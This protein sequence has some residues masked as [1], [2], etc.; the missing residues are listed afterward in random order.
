MEQLREEDAAYFQEMKNIKHEII[1]HLLLHCEKIAIQYWSS[2]SEY[3]LY[4]KI[5]SSEDNEV[6]LERLERNF[7]GKKI[8]FEVYTSEPE[9]IDDNIKGL[10]IM[11]SFDYNTLVQN[12]INLI[13][14][15]KLEKLNGKHRFLGWYI[16]KLTFNPKMNQ[17][18][19][20]RPCL[21][22][23]EGEFFF[24]LSTIEI[25]KFDVLFN[26][27]IDEKL[28]IEVSKMNL[29]EFLSKLG[30]EFNG[31]KFEKYLTTEE[32]AQQ[33]KTN[34]KGIRLF[35]NKN[36]A[37]NKFIVINNAFYDFSQYCEI[38]IGIEGEFQEEN[39]WSTFR[40]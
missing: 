31:S 4:T 32:L 33:N 35:E 17:L 25:T 36:K 21:D 40:V 27:T 23:D 24:F 28:Q 12:E 26:D 10:E 15:E 38:Q 20:F 14:K 7:K 18:T 30:N 9:F 22:E 13:E 37:S 29:S 16:S 3:E 5:Y 6:I 34:T 39:D 2:D 11:I 8:S 19:L 1:D